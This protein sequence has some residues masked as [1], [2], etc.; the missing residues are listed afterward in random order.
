MKTI[1]KIGLALVIIMGC[2]NAGRALMTEYRFEDA[3]HEALLFNPRM[4]DKEIIA[5]VLET[6][7]NFD[8]PME[9]GNIRIRDQGP[10]VIV[11]MSYTTTVIVFPRILEKEWTFTP[12]ATT[13]NLVGGKRRAS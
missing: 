5:M 3:V 12:S 13:R 1:I 10:D 6:A 9:V 8:V 7:S 11:E 2:V 4:T